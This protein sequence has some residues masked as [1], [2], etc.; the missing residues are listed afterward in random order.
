VL[1][2]D[3]ARY[4]LRAGAAHDA[5]LR[6][7]DSKA[8]LL[9]DLAQRREQRRNPPRKRRVARER[10]IVRVARVAAAE[11]A[12]ESRAALIEAPGASPESTR[13]SPCLRVRTQRF[14]APNGTTLFS[15]SCPIS[16]RPR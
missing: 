1:V 16:A 15:T 13:A 4:A 2:D 7:I 3:D 11:S 8:L 6:A 14:S 10:E 5:C 12:R 9:R